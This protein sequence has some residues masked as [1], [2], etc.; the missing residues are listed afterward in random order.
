MDTECVCL[1]L[2]DFLRASKK[3]F[4]FFVFFIFS[5]SINYSSAENFEATGAGEIV[6]SSKFGGLTQEEFEKL[7]QMQGA[8][9][10]SIQENYQKFIDGAKQTSE[11]GSGRYSGF[12][13]AH[14]GV[15]GIS[16]HAYDKA[17]KEN[18]KAALGSDRLNPSE[19]I[20]KNK[21]ITDTYCE[22]ITN[23][24]DKGK[25]RNKFSG[26]IQIKNHSI[27]AA[28][29]DA[30]AAHGDK[31]DAHRVYGVKESV[32]D[33]SKAFG[34][35]YGDQ[36]IKDAT[37]AGHTTDLEMLRIAQGQLEQ[38]KYVHTAAMA[39]ALKGARLSGDPSSADEFKQLALNV[40]SKNKGNIL[41]AED[42]IKKQLSERI[43]EHKVLGAT[44]FCDSGPDIGNL[45]G[46]GATC[47]PPVSGTS[48]TQMPISDLAK[49]VLRK[50][51]ESNPDADV[52][53][54]M[55]DKINEKLGIQ[56]NSG[57][58][59]KSLEDIYPLI[60]ISDLSGVLEDQSMKALYSSVKPTSN[61]TKK[62]DEYLTRL[63]KCLEFNV[64]CFSSG[65]N[66]A[67]N[68]DGTKSYAGLKLDNDT[69]QRPIEFQV[70]TGDPGNYFHDTRELLYSNSAYAA[71]RPLSEA[72][73]NI[74]NDDFN[75]HTDSK[76]RSGYN[77]N[78]D[79][80]KP[81]EQFDKSYKEAMATANAIRNY[82]SE[83]IKRYKE[84]GATKADLDSLKPIYNTDDFDPTKR[85]QQ[86]LF[87]AGN[88]K[89]NASTA[90]WR[91][92]PNA[93]LLDPNAR[94]PAASNTQGNS[95]AI[96]SAKKPRMN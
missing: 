24:N 29:Y 47:A 21:E 70:I 54:R 37:K 95:R 43:A 17:E 38:Q 19:I 13:E 62:M 35:Q 92:N 33:A 90:A 27:S 46:N 59:Q 50:L 4:L 20:K 14:V 41:K 7:K 25:C 82:D 36:I 34:G 75:E 83:V 56:P 78:K 79:D 16:P 42:E 2:R 74:R 12:G 80:L 81:Y 22:Q 69:P 55:E 96:P 64:F 91:V 32:R 61:Q 76:L 6:D 89:V 40:Y 52:I 15:N 87:G 28:I 85:T 49:A 18:V 30:G 77:R 68:A 84:A 71:S 73:K 31:D 60:T 1:D 26:E 65:T 8:Y 63:P 3:A 53:A 88:L 94:N 9:S 93:A 67:R 10:K 51:G 44:G 5:F 48:P 11:G 66:D 23:G 72:M 45:M 58:N 39:Y 57:P 86:Q